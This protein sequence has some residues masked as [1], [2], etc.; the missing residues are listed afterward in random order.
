MC[1]VPKMVAFGFDASILQICSLL[2]AE[3]PGCEVG[4]LALLPKKGHF[5]KFLAAGGEAINP[6]GVH[7]V[8]LGAL[9]GGFIAGALVLAIKNTKFLV[10]LKVNYPYPTAFREI[11]DSISLVS[12]QYSTAII[13]TRY[14]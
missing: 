2:I 12:R 5:A 6:A 8:S 10:H 9:V 14:E 7:L 4:P 13:N 1:M 3:K 11:F